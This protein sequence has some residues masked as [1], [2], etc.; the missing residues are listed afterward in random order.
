LK[1]FLSIL[2]K[3]ALLLLRDWP[4]LAILFIMPA[5]LLIVLTFIQE[6]AIPATSS[7]FKMII[8]NADSSA[9]GD[10]IVQDLTNSKYFNFI[11]YGTTEEAKQAI[12]DGKS[13]FAVIISDSATEKLFNLIR[14]SSESGKDTNKIPVSNL[15]GVVFLY[16]PAMPSMIKDAINMPLKTFIQLSAVKILVAQYAEEVNKSVTKHSSDFAANLSKENY[17]NNIPDFPYKNEIIKRFNDEL[18]KRT[19]EDSKINLPVNLSFNSEIVRIDE[20]AARNEN[21]DFKPNALQHNIPAF[22]LFAMFFIVIPLAGSILNEKINGTFNRLKTF[23]VS[24][25]EIISSKIAVFLIVCIL[26][27]IFMMFVG[28]YIMP[29]L[30]ELSS[31]NLNVSYPA[32]LLALIASSLAAIGFGIIVGTFA[33]THGQAATFGSVMVVI[34]A[35]LGGIFVP[36]S[37]M[38]KILQGI[39]MISPLR[40]GTDAFL[41]VFNRDE[42]IGKIWLE[43]CLLFGFFGASIIF[44]LR[45]FKKH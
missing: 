3:D 19:K 7:G 38:P 25:I 40:W 9:L 44:S 1:K 39:S 36:S 8:V 33:S 17:F 16:D 32:L 42:G 2:K 35:L 41:S 31:I 6:N 4:G 45:I 21:S 30:G 18:N 5:V 37:L 15:A 24:Y 27:F 12:L 34:L 13:Q 11:R 26:Q 20:L 10:N 14:I 43:L 22:T 29:M 28:I 23:P